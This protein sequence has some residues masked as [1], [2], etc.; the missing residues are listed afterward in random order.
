[1][2]VQCKPTRNINPIMRNDTLSKIVL[3]LVVNVL[4][5]QK[6]YIVCKFTKTDFSVSSVNTENIQFKYNS[7]SLN[8]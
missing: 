6:Q 5:L 3:I 2:Y 4:I 8:K 7:Q 1:M